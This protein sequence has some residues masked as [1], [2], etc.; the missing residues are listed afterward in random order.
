MIIAAPQWSRRVGRPPLVNKSRRPRRRGRATQ[1]LDFESNSC[2]LWVRVI[3]F[4]TSNG[5]ILMVHRLA[6]IIAGLL[7]LTVIPYSAIGADL[8]GPHN[9]SAGSLNCRSV[10]RCGPNGCGWHRNCWHG[11]PDGISCFPLYGAYGPYGG[12]AYWGAYS[13]NVWDYYP[14]LG[15]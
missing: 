3:A 9:R 1:I 2:K 11:C 15:K 7:T 5:G 12:S 8:L 4:A 14:P 6:A 10:W 13:Y